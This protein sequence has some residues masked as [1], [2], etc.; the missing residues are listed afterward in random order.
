M[1]VAG[2]GSRRSSRTLA[3]LDTQTLVR[4]VTLITFRKL[5]RPSH[6]LIQDVYTGGPDFKNELRIDC[7]YVSTYLGRT[8]WTATSRQ[9]DVGAAFESESR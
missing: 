5:S 1:V 2:I 7:R 4:L 8:S 3:Q 6:Y 9:I